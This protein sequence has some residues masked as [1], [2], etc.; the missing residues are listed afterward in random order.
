[1]LKTTTQRIL[2]QSRGFSTIMTPRA[3]LHFIEHPRYGKVYPVLSYNFD[4]SYFKLPVSSFLG[5]GFVNSLVFY[6]A[7]VNQIFT[8]VIHSFL[9]NPLFVLP[10]LYLNY[11][12]VQRYLIYFQVGALSHVQTMF[13]KENGKGVIVETRDG[14]THEI[15]N[16]KFYNPKRIKNKWEDRTDLYFGANNYLFLRGNAQIM[17]LEVLNAVVKNKTI[18]C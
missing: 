4:R 3:R 15:E 17:D 8:P 16:S 1:M 9:C 10:S 13:L 6:G 18:D 7:F 14:E 11:A 2:T 5:M 12:L